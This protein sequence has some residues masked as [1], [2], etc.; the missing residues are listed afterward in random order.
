MAR[1]VAQRLGLDVL[2]TGA[3]YRAATLA[4]LRDRIALDDAGSL[5][6]LT[7]RMALVVDDRVLLDGRDVTAEIRGPE[8]TA[9]V[10]AVSAHEGV[11]AVLVARQRAWAETRRGGVVEGRDIGTVVFP[12]A[13]V[14]VFLTASDEE[15]ARRRTRDEAGTARAADLR[16]VAASMARRDHLDSNRAASPLVAAADA[17]VVDTTGRTVDDI[18]AEIV[19]RAELA[20]TPERGAH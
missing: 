12:D 13:A 20:F 19:R 10:S 7:E 15:R 9:A 18:V 16:D 6:D 5:R 2:D 11:R 4:A 1:A 17:V 8:V 3:M 14:K